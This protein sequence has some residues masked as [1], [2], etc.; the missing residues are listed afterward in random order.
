MFNFMCLGVS[1]LSQ[2]HSLP[3]SRSQPPTTSKPT[4]APT[5]CN[6]IYVEVKVT[7]DNWPEET[8]WS[9]RN[10]C[11]TQVVATGGSY[12]AANTLHSV[13]HCLPTAQY[14]FT[15][16]DSYGDGICCSEGAGSYAVVIDGVTTLTNGQFT[17]SETKTFG[18]CGV[19]PL[20][21]YLFYLIDYLCIHPL[22]CPSLPPSLRKNV[23]TVMPTAMPSTVSPTA[24]AT[25]KPTTTKPSTQSPSSKPT[26]RNP[27]SKPTTRKP[28]TRKPTTRKPTTRKPTTRKPTTRK[29]V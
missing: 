25:A 22:T 7:T 24:A 21:R 2:K 3:P 26:T 18:T 29:P 5:P 1:I 17:S 4:S 9:L 13:K 23:P 15:I 6:G 28:T 20:K 11:T 8:T 14:S 10:D 19:S 27:T 16:N 12:T